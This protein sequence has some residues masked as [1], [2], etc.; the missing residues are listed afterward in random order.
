M[1]QN[2]NHKTILIIEDDF[3]LNDAFCLILQHVGYNT[4]S[5]HNGRDALEYLK[6][7]KADLILLDILMPVMDGREFMRQFKNT[8]AIP[9]VAL[10]NLD[11]KSEIEYIQSL[12]ITKYMLKSTASPN[13]LIELVN[14]TL[15]GKI[16]A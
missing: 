2:N 3:A 10:S 1:K 14:H 6:E 13:D 4:V 16:D 5:A 7:N 9:I 12:G 11:A 15:H 8:T